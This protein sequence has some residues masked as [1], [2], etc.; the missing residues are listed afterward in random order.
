[1]V[2]SSIILHEE[3]NFDEF[4]IRNVNFKNAKP[5]SRCRMINNDPMNGMVKTEPLKTLNT[6]R[7][8]DKSFFWYKYHPVKRRSN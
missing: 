1:M 3:D 8:E 5:F 7:K 2:V 6:Y 4:R